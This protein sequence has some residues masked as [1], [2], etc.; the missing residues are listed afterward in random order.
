V[1]RGLRRCVY[2]PARWGAVAVVGS[3]A[4]GGWVQEGERV[5]AMLRYGVTGMSRVVVCERGRESLDLNN[6]LGSFA[7]IS[8]G[9]AR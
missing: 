7:I 1:G 2:F 9:P 5:D 4:R 6:K 3:E 8:L